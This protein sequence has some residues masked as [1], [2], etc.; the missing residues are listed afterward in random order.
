MELRNSL[1][2]LRFGRDRVFFLVVGGLFLAYVLTISRLNLVMFLATVVALLL[3]ITV[4]ECAHAWVADQ[5]GDPT[6]R[7]AGRISLNPVVHLDPFG[8][9]MLLF[10]ASAGMGIGWGK[11]VPVSP[12]RLRYGPRLGNG[13]VA[14]SGPLSNLLLAT[15]LGLV[16]RIAVISMLRFALPLSQTVYAFLAIAVSINISLALF[17]LL[18]LPPLDGHSVLL[19][20][21]SLSHDSWAWRA[22]Q[23]VASLQQH[24]P[25]L[26]LGLILISQFSGLNLIGWLIGPPARFFLRLMLGVGG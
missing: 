19:G 21:L 8:T 11:P 1:K 25:L 20:L 22:S 23:F 14:L 12:Y 7:D 17:N 3:A 13:L 6:A 5:L 15:V 18:P 24:G 9:V 2:G 26:L 16:L 4:H 10:M